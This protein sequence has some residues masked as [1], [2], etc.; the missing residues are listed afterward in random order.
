[1]YRKPIFT[2]QYVHWNSFSPMKR[3]I[4]LV[5]TLVHRV[6]FICS[7]SKLQTDL[8]KIR[9]ILFANGYPNHIITFTFSKKIRQFKHLNMDPRN[10]RFISI[11]YGWEIFQ[12]N[13]KSKL[14]Q[15]FS[16]ATLLLKHVFFLQPGLFFR[17][18][19]GCNHHN[20]VIYHFVC[21]CVGRTSQR[22]Q[23]RI[24]QRVPRSIKNIHSSQDRFN[25]SRACKKNS[26]YQIIAQCLLD[27]IF[28]KTFLV[29]ANYS[30][31][32]LMEEEMGKG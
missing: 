1:M 27:S 23:E 6:M 2:G 17:N 12:T 5:A 19:A 7:S 9:S 20:N 28:W 11:F 15:P 29:A 26:T 22:L 32:E 3:K 21:H 10:A 24:K 16:V 13:S 18:Q 14:L 25:F 8:G 4:N 30:T 31:T